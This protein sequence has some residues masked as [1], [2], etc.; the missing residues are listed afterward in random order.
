[1]IVHRIYEWA[2]SQPDKAA[3]VYQGTPLSYATF[4]RAIEATR[5]FLA[6]CHLPAGRTAIVLVHNL[7]DSWLCIF[8]LRTLGLDTI[9]VAAIA[10][11]EHLSVKHDAPIVTTQ[12][13]RRTHSVENSTLPSSQIITVPMS[14]Y[15]RIHGGALPAMVNE[16]A[17]CGGHVLLTSGTTG[18]EKMIHLDASAEDHRNAVLSASH[19]IDHRTIDHCV[20]LGLR[21]GMGY[22]TPLNVWHCGGTILIDQS[23]EQFSN[24]SAL[25]MNMTFLVPQML[26]ELMAA[27]G[28]RAVLDDELNLMIGGGFVSLRTVDY[29]LKHLSKTIDITYGCTELGS[30]IMRARFKTPADLHWLAPLEGRTVQVVDEAGRELPAGEEGELRIL[31]TDI[32][33]TAYLGDEPSSA[34]SFRDGYFHPGDLAVRRAD[35]RIRILGRTADVLN[36]QGNKMAV[37]PIEQ[38]IQARL[39]VEQVCVFSGLNEEGVEEVVIAI[40]SDREPAKSELEAVA[41]NFAGFGRARFEILPAFPR[42]GA[43]MGKVSRRLLRRLVFPTT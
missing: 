18:G 2:R 32:D 40:Q 33:A 13:Y 5:Q 41:R 35:G 9:A 38:R 15:A 22:K 10:Q 26:N 21:T 3:I 16:N 4:A 24:F 6:Q 39:Q 8:A 30:V 1:M 28:A 17:P 11:A 34:E 23:K 19:A 25:R 36:M 31:T 27:H 37:A 7:V 29:A 14:I 43:G 42:T 12:A 20:G